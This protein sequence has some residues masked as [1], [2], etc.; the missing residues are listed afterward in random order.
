MYIHETIQKNVS[1]L[2]WNDRKIELGRRVVCVK[3]ESADG[4]RSFEVWD[5][6]LTT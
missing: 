2:F 1:D 5:L 3:C 4:L 6:G